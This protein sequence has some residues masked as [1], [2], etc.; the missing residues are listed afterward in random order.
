[1]SAGIVFQIETSRVLTVLAKEI[2]DSPHALLRENVQN[3]Y[4]A[5][6]MRFAPSERLVDGRI[7]ITVSD[8][9]VTISDN[10]IGMSEKDLREHFWRPGA[11]GKHSASARDAGVVGTFGI[12]AMANF[13]VCKKLIVETRADGSS[14]VLRSVAERASLK[15]AEECITLEYLPESARGVGTTV[16]AVLDDQHRLSEQQVKTYLEPYVGLL[17]VAVYLNQSLVSCAAIDSKLP[18][19]GRTFSLIGIKVLDDGLCRANFEVSIDANGQAMVKGTNVTLGG[20]AIEGELALVQSGGT[21]MGLRSYFGLAPI[22][23]IGTYQLG[24]L[25]NLS[26]LQPTAGREALSRESIQQVS[27]LLALAE[28]AIS[29]LVAQNEL[30][31]NNTGFQQWIVAHGRYDLAE[32]ISVQ[33]L[34]EN[35][36]IPLRRTIEFSAGRTVHYYLGTDQHTRTTFSSQGSCLLL[37]S[38]NNP[39]RQIQ[40][41]VLKTIHRIPEVPDHIRVTKTFKGPD[42]TLAEASI[43]IRISSILREDYLIPDVEVYL[44][45]ISHGVTIRPEKKG[46]TLTVYISRSSA[47]LPSLIEFYNNAYELFGQF[48]KDFV[49]LHVYPHIQTFV[50]S[51]TRD[52]VDVLRKVLERNRELYRYEETERG[53]FEGVLGEYLSGSTSLNEI[54]GLARQSVRPQSQRVSQHEIDTIENVLPTVVHSPVVSAPAEGGEFSPVPPIL[55]EDISSEMKI[56]TTTNRYAQLNNFRML[57]GLSDR[58]MR[59]NGDFFRTPH[60]TRILWGGHRVIFIFTETTGRLSLYYDV[61]L[62]EPIKHENAGGCML[63]STTLIT[64]KRIFVPVPDTLIPD[65][66]LAVGPK[67]FFVR[68]DVL[69]SD[70]T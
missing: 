37:V 66:Q 2:Y 40:L 70:V 68:F 53:D 1:M 49:R 27:R 33:V 29:E 64:K 7:E 59:T 58:L 23:A 56:L 22:P 14:Q 6:R 55:R 63:P 41:H 62:R 26:F 15:I 65:F 21:L 46:S 3:A 13:G 4:D 32:M 28:R 51:S 52:G 9:S 61:E 25:V 50:P 39:R 36:T 20:N 31:D 16:I 30:A 43:T 11:S 44:A 19:A 60:T 24:G 8:G 67:E 34:P 69:T 47:L 42:I 18:I 38:Q 45:S 48:M 12:G 54:I 35:V 57:L 10:G 17:P 5:V